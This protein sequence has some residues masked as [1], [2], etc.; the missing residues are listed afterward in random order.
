MQGTVTILCAPCKGAKMS[1]KPK[2]KRGDL[3]V[4]DHHGSA[5]E[6]LEA[7][8]LGIVLGEDGRSVSDNCATYRVNWMLGDDELSGDEDGWSEEVLR[9]YKP[10]VDV[11]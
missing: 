8:S 3:V 6:Y 2:F 1:P 10:P 11:K 5:W 7:G 9:H 4:Y